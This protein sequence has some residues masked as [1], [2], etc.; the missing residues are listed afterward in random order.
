MV[1]LL[2]SACLRLLAPFTSGLL[3]GGGGGGE[4]ILPCRV[5]QM[6]AL[7]RLAH[8]VCLVRL[9]RLLCSHVPQCIHPEGHLDL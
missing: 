8:L 3:R 7:L 6:H 4:V 5:I 1:G 2:S 9:V